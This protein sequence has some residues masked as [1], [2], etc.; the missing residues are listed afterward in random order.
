MG[1]TIERCFL[2]ARVDD[3]SDDGGASRSLLDELSTRIETITRE[4]RYKDLSIIWTGFTYPEEDF[5]D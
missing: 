1:G 5:D 2:S 4:T 3:H